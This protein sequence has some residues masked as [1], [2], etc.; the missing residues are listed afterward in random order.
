MI[1]N[2]TVAGGSQ[3][4][5]RSLIDAS[6]KFLQI[7]SESEKLEEGILQT[8]PANRNIVYDDNLFD[9]NAY[10]DWN[11]FDDFDQQVINSNPNK[12]KIYNTGGNTR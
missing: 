10:N 1:T 11:Q 3:I 8:L 5:E 6:D 2:L 9:P 7:Q 12:N 4:G